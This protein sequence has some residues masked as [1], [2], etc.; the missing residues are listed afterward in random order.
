MSLLHVERMGGFAGFGGSG[1]RIRSHGHID[2]S[3]LSAA[4]QQSV[5]SLFQKGAVTGVA[6]LPDEFRYRISRTTP[7]GT[8]VIEAPESI[9][10]TAL[11][12]CVRDELV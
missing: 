1:A 3:S 10:P 11:A 4:E 9:I 7:T 6:P 12:Q 2:A 8:E 5:E